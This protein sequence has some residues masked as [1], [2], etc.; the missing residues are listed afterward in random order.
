MIYQIAKFNNYLVLTIKAKLEDNDPTSLIDI[1]TVISQDISGSMGSYV[2]SKNFNATKIKLCK[3]THK[4]VTRQLL[5]QKFGVVA[6]DDRVEIISKLKTVNNLIEINSLIDSMNFRGSTDLHSGI[7]SGLDQFKDSSADSV[8]YL[9][10]FTDGKTNHGITSTLEIVQDVK[11]KLEQLPKGIKLI[12]MGYGSDSDMDLLDAIAEASQGN[13]HCLTNPNDIPCVIGEELGCAMQ[14]RFNCIN[15]DFNQDKLKY[16][17]QNQIKEN[18]LVLGELLAGEEKHYLFQL[19]NDGDVNGEEDKLF[20]NLEAF[21]CHTKETHL[22]G[23][24]SKIKE[25]ENLINQVMWVDKV[26]NLLSQIQLSTPDIINEQLDNAIIEIQKLSSKNH[27]IEKLLETLKNAKIQSQNIMAPAVLRSM[28]DSVHK[29]RG[30]EFSTPYV[31]NMRSCS[32]SFVERSI[33]QHERDLDHNPIYKNTTPLSMNNR[34]MT[35]LPPP[36]PIT[37]SR[38]N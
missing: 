29:Q 36:P 1:E 32:S 31:K 15:L 20:Y 35:G 12:L 37:R 30:G 10:V 33:E 27:I 16:L 4:F 13:V 18:K 21:D 17:G 22:Y 25:D 2:H 26:G 8:K 7:I 34:S 3:E 28:S 24:F 5:G 23:D 38:A 19:K 9:F 6:F 11:N 14:T